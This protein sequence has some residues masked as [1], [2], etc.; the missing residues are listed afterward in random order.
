MTM[1]DN[2]SNRPLSPHLQVYRFTMTM[3]MSIF[4]R[5]T[6]VGLYLGTALLAWWL[7]AAA[8]GPAYFDFVNSIFG[9]WIGLVV[10]FLF[11]WT[12]IHHMLGGIRHFIMDTGR[13]LD[14][15]MRDNLAYV[16]LVG[17]ILVTV[18]VWAFSYGMG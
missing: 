14:E 1:T 9:S 17:S 15:P 5:I 10:L 12:L 4:H 3:A 7:M 18:F 13:G 16:A 6:G 8:S 2:K 11:T